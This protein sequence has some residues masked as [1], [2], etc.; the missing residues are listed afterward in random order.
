MPSQNEE[1]L[2]RG[3]WE[4]VGDRMVPDASLLRIRDFIATELEKIAECA[5]GWETLF[6]NRFDGR[7]WERFYPLGEM[8]GG[9]P[10]SLRRID[11]IAAEQKY[12]VR[13]STPRE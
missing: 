8:H 2:I 12:K 4:R 9:G 6:R 13:L 1:I 5:G 7:F 10:E 11:V 3:G